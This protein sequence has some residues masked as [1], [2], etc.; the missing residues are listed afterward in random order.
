VT[1]LSTA[2]WALPSPAAAP[3]QAV[4]AVP[5][6]ADVPVPRTVRATTHIGRLP[7]DALLGRHVAAPSA[8]DVDPRLLLVQRTPTGPSTHLTRRTLTAP[9]DERR[10]Q[11][12]RHRRLVLCAVGGSGGLLLAGLSVVSALT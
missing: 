11:R 6:V 12:E 7:M 4:P 9:A 8:L 5:A 3:E 1:A 2:L 10:E